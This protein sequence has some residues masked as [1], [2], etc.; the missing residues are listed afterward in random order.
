MILNMNNF[1]KILNGKMC[2]FVSDLSPQQKYKLAAKTVMSHVKMYM[3][4]HLDLEILRK[5]PGNAVE[6]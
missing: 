2:D 3:L 1:Y 5:G 6:Q 4:Y